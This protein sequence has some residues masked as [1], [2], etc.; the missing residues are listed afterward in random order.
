[1]KENQLYNQF[2]TY[3]QRV[4]DIQHATAVLHWDQEIFMPKNAAANRARQSATLS[5][6]AHRMATSEELR[7]FLNELMADDSLDSIQRINV[8][9]SNHDFLKATKIPE[10]FVE[11][12]QHAISESFQAWSQAKEADDYSLFAPKLKT[13]IELKKEEAEIVGYDHH[14]Y[15]ALMDDYEPGMKIEVLDRVFDQVRQQLPILLKKISQTPQVDNSFLF[16]SFNKDSQWDFSLHVLR[17]MGYDF[18]EG[19]QDITSH[20]FTTSFGPGDVRVTTRVAEN[21]LGEII[22]STIH[23]GGHALYEQGLMKSEYGLP[24]GSYASLSVHESQSRLWENNVG[25]SLPYWKHMFADL[26]QRFPKQLASVS[27]ID[28]F[29]GTNK[30]EPSLIRTSADELTYHFHVLIRYEIEKAIFSKEVEVEDLPSLW[31]EK[32]KKYLEIEVPSDQKGIL[33]DVHWSYG[34]FGYFPTYSLGS[35][36]AAQYYEAAK[37]AIP[38]LE[39]NI[40]AGNT[41][42]L[43]SWL[44]DQIHKHGRRYNAEELCKKVTGKGLDFNDFY[45]YAFQK[46]QTIYGF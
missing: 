39:Q 40:E 8:E 23:E 22:W 42:E 30:V 18:D 10:S 3:M 1:M 25:R 46:Y 33:Q 41:K 28:F 5:G 14:P 38:N 20:P 43:L 24:S 44:R 19:R 35:F 6:V 7:S 2:V 16:K 13:L 21:D 36:Y 17:E 31:N 15:E 45:N 9:K 4:A 12:L 27:D 29:K 11:K 34:S 26:K 37:Q 32:Y